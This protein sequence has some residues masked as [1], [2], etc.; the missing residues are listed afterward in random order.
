MVTFTAT[1]CLSSPAKIPA[2]EY[3]LAGAAH[4]YGMLGDTTKLMAVLSEVRTNAARVDLTIVYPH[5][6]VALGRLKQVK[7]AKEREEMF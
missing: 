3:T 4:T 2:D 6:L 7:R 1:S 5:L